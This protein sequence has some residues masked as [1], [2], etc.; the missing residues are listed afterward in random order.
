LQVT[1]YESTN[2]V[3]RLIDYTLISINLRY[4]LRVTRFELR[5]TGL[6]DLRPTAAKERADLR[7]ERLRIR[8]YCRLHET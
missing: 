3:D 1:S 7:M 8:E 6:Y 5:V 4:E 2:T